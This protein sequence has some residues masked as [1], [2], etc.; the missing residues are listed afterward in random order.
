MLRTLVLLLFVANLLFYAWT[1]GWL[2]E[3]HP[4]P[5][6]D[7][8]REPERALSEVRP[9]SM[10]ILAVRP[11]VGAPALPDAAAVAADATRSAGPDD[12]GAASDGSPAADPFFGVSTGPSADRPAGDGAEAVEAREGAAQPSGTVCLEVGPLL[13]EERPRAEAALRAV[14]APGAWEERA[15]VRPGLW[16]VYMGPYTT[17]EALQAKGKELRDIGV[18]YAE[19]RSAG[20]YESGLSLG[21]FEQ[22]ANADAE[23]RRLATRYGVRSA[24]VV[25]VR[26]P[27]TLLSFRVP[28]ADARTQEAL[29]GLSGAFAGKRFKSCND[30]AVAASAP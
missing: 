19:V 6:H 14:L 16:M 9:D 8:P 25:A 22:R 18:T 20:P 7:A 27:Q 2:D 21:R 11:P 30:A 4:L 26:A 28:Q 13:N 24:R 12:P 15:S 5:R 3:L 29:T 17:P 23:L 1:Q 10:R